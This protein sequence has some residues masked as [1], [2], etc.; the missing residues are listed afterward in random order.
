MT[1]SITSAVVIP[2]YDAIDAERSAYL[3][4]WERTFISAGYAYAT[5][6]D[7]FLADAERQREG[8]AEFAGY[9]RGEINPRGKRE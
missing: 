9:L 5:I 4:E 2:D 6:E 1:N 3:A 7:A 8:F